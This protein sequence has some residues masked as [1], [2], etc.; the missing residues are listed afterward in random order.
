MQTVNKTKKTLSILLIVFVVLICIRSFYQ[1]ASVTYYYFDSAGSQSVSGVITDANCE[2]N[3]HRGDVFDLTI[4]NSA[5]KGVFSVAGFFTC[6]KLDIPG[7][8]I[9]KRA[10]ILVDSRGAVSG[11]SL[12][13]KEIYS[14]KEMFWIRLISSLVVGFFLLITTLILLKKYREQQ[15][16][17]ETPAV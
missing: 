6:E 15:E 4:S 16:L 17:D 2:E 1:A 5:G 13:D 12:E 7:D 11:L 3:R 8:Y 9:N 10:V 14:K